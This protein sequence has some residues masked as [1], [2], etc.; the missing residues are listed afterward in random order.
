MV[1]KES[2]NSKITTQEQQE[3]Q[4]IFSLE[5]QED[6]KDSKL[7]K[8]GEQFSLKIPRDFARELNIDPT[9]HFF[10]FSLLVS[11]KEPHKKKLHGELIQDEESKEK[12]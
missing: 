11:E 1:E 9:K 7:T 12:D 5:K 8:D 2:L 3:L 10:R 4:E 6:I